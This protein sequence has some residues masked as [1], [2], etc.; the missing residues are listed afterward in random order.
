M[1]HGNLLMA[2]LAGLALYFGAAGGALADGM[3]KEAYKAAKSRIE[4]SLKDEVRACDAQKGNPRDICRAT[5]EGHA[6]VALAELEAQY[7][8]GPD[9]MAREMVA[10]AKAD[11]EVARQRCAGMAAPARDAC[12]AQAENKRDAGVRQAKLEHVATLRRLKALNASPG[13]EPASQ[14]ID[15]KFA[16][17]KARCGMLGEARDSCLAD[18]KRRFNRS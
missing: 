7:E 10:Q 17:Q 15:E 8:P 6:K 3:G 12:R 9:A 5:A 14:S 16:A 18:V 1:K 4:A 11:Y 2:G 13:K